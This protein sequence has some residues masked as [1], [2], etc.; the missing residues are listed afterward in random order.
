MSDSFAYS[1]DT[2]AEARRYELNRDIR[3]VNCRHQINNARPDP[4]IFR[5]SLQIADD[6]WQRGGDDGLT[7]GEIK[8]GSGQEISVG[9]LTW[10]NAARKV[11]AIKAANTMGRLLWGKWW[12]SPAFQAAPG[13]AFFSS[14]GEGGRGA[15]WDFSS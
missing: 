4:A 8:V 9:G 5:T 13:S 15:S 11:Q 2:A 7:E 1:G 10:S 14:V 6:C 3:I 12:V